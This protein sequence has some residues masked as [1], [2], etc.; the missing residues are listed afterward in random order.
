MSTNLLV[1]MGERSNEKLEMKE[2]PVVSSSEEASA[3]E[4]EDWDR[5][6]GFDAVQ[7][8]TLASSLVPG[9]FSL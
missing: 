9:L 3:A 4:E 2:V 5:E 7:R 1:S 6:M 8:A